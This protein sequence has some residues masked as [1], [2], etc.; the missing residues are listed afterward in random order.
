MGRMIFVSGSGDNTKGDDWTT[1]YT[2]L[3]AALDAAAE[4]DTIH[5][6]GETFPIAAQLVWTN[7]GV[8]L[9]GGY[10]GNDAGG[11]PGPRDPAQWP[12]VIQRDGTAV[13]RILLITNVVNGL[14]DGVTLR[15]GETAEKAAGAGL[16]LASCSN[17]VVRSCI[18]EANRAYNNANNLG[19][20]AGGGL[21]A[22]DSYAH[23]SNTVFRANTGQTVYSSTYSHALGG[24]AAIEGGAVQLIDCLWADNRLIAARNAYGSGLYIEGGRHRIEHGVFQGNESPLSQGGL[25]FNRGDG[26]HI[27]GAS[28]VVSVCNA[29]FSAN[30]RD[31]IHLENG[32]LAITNATIVGHGRYGARRVGGSLTLANS[33]LWQNGTHT[34]GTVALNHCQTGVD[35]LF[36][37]GL[38]LASGSP[39][40]DAGIESVA[41]PAVGNRSTAVA[42]TPDTGTVDLGYHFRSAAP[43]SAADAA[44]RHDPALA[45][46]YVAP[47]GDDGNPGT[48]AQPFRSITRALAAASS[49]SHIQI[50]AGL[51]TNGVET[52]PIEL[53]KPGLRLLGAGA[54]VTVVNAGG[55]ATAKRVL[56]A[57]GVTGDGV[58]EGATITG[59]YIPKTP[60]ESLLAFDHENHRR[61]R[62]GAGMHLVN[63]SLR[64]VDTA[65]T[66]NTMLGAKNEDPLG[67][68]VYALYSWGTLTNSLV[69]GNSITS[70]QSNT[71]AGYGGG[72]YLRGGAWRVTGCRILDNRSDFAN[73]SGSYGGGIAM[74][75]PHELLDTVIAG[76]R[77]S[78]QDGAIRRGGGIHMTE[79]LVDRCLIASNTMTYTASAT[80][81][82][83][84]IHMEG[85]VIRNSLVMANQAERDGGAIYATG[86]LIESVTAAG[87]CSVQAGT[88]AGLCLSGV[89]PLVSNSISYANNRAFDN[90]DVSVSEAGGALAYSCAQ[91]AREGP[92]NTDADPEFADAAAGNVR[93]LPGSP[94]IDSAAV[95]A[96]MAGAT[97]FDGN[98]RV[99]HAVPDRGA[100]EAEPPDA[101][102]LRANFIADQRRGI[103]NLTVTLTAY[104][105]GSDTNGLV[106]SWD[107]DNDGT[108][109]VSGADKRVIVHP[110]TPGLFS[111][112]LVVVNGA[113]DSAAWVKKD[114]IRVSASDIFVWSGGGHSGGTSWATAFTNLQEALDFATGSNTVYL[115]GETFNLG[116]ELVWSAVEGVQIL[117][118]YAAGTG[119]VGPGPC[120]PARWPTVIRQASGTARV[121]SLAGLTGCRL[122]RVTIAN[123]NTPVDAVKAFGGGVYILLSDIE[124]EECVISNNQANASG[125]GYVWGGGIYALDSTVTLRRTLFTGNVAKSTPGSNNN[126]AHGGGLASEN[127]TIRLFECRF[128]GN[129]AD[130]QGYRGSWGGAVYL[131]GG[132]GLIRNTLMAGNRAG[133]VTARGLGGAIYLNPGTAL[134][135]CTIAGNQ[136]GGN[137]ALVATTAA[138][139]Y[140]QGGTVTN[141]IIYYNT[142]TFLAAAADVYTT[143]PARFGF[144]CA[145]ELVNA[146]AGNITTA[147]L[148]TDS[149]AGDY[150][151]LPASPCRNAGLKQ[152]WMEEAVDLAGN[153]RIAA[154]SADIG[155]FE[156]MPPG[157]M[158]LLVR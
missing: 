72:L 122:A 32:T 20:L 50:D 96:W 116:A 34:E 52:F 113:S 43:F 60:T 137:P 17:L 125:N 130:A 150:S 124:I 114:Y 127:S 85:G 40:I 140:D 98:P 8:S 36:E 105:S 53:R 94:A 28:T 143:V 14:L 61:M 13:H 102:V 118:G 37:R 146:V 51:Y 107:F 71:G 111:V 66:N 112:R 24:G 4:G 80:A 135:S 89:A 153:K 38:Y 82:G 120:D 117:G 58:I 128:I 49:G 123:G 139:I 78:G 70:G 87:N 141:S 99:R 126:R 142:N 5:V 41:V 119:T 1:A 39:A 157:A 22:S 59:G 151:L 33:I 16:K 132:T 145:P 134:E 76:N 144:S 149:A 27:G 83:G 67:G 29:L 65:I 35:P 95:L 156:I 136:C 154:G 21:Y 9:L 79:G 148:F 54:E 56:Q 93:L 25:S 73:N 121:L 84:G 86:G 26:L 47:D 55:A 2:N 77:V 152:T 155:A 138:G 81:H 115:A 15:G 91:P 42:G 12:T 64:I 133:P 48:S 10:A 62:L 30:L 158:L 110:Y 147:P 45:S 131:L 63:S 104:V 7:A 90:L 3:Q 74:F 31:G 129:D 69:A 101:G 57:R 19:N 46:L 100:F 88:V 6:A 97:D 68:G 108:I 103:D 18:I 106:Y 75:G 92:G 109:D 23:F 11:L 44:V